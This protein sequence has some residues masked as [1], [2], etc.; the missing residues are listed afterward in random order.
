MG[1]Q[2][3]E[4][5]ILFPVLQEPL[6]QRRHC[7]SAIFD[8]YI[9]GWPN[10]HVLIDHIFVSSAVREQVAGAGVAHDLWERHG[11]PSDHRPIYVD[12]KE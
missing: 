6:V 12:L 11:Q 8:D 4:T 3:Y 10:K 7:W 9:E 5:Q 1:S 2:F